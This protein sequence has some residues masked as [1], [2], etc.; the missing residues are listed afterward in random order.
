MPNKKESSP[1]TNQKKE[2]KKKANKTKRTKQ[3]EEPENTESDSDS[4]SDEDE[5]DTAE[6]TDKRLGYKRTRFN[7][8]ITSTSNPA[9]KETKTANRLSVVDSGS[10]EHMVKDLQDLVSVA[11]KYQKESDPPIRINA[12]N[13]NEMQIT[14]SGQIANNIKHN[15]YVS[16]DLPTEEPNLLSGSKLQKQGCYIIMPPTNTQGQVGCIITDSQ[17]RVMGTTK[18][19]L[20]IEPADIKLTNMRISVLQQIKRS[21][22]NHDK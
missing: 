4:E 10:E 1:R 13:G 22:I 20:L 5:Y 3:K 19:D 16:P 2:P 8:R 11:A 17:G 12:A 18:K 15:A 9:E 21:H 14:A 6:E 7:K